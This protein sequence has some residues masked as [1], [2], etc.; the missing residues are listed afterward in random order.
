MHRLRRNVLTLRH[1]RPFDSIVADQNRNFRRNVKRA[2]E[3]ATEL[4]LEFAV[5]EGRLAVTQQLDIIA[6]IARASWKHT[7]RDG[8]QISVPYEGRQRRFFETLLADEDLGMTPFVATASVRSEPV[9]ALLC[10]QHARNFTGLLMFRDERWSAASPGLLLLGHIIDRAALGEIQRFDLNAIQDWLRHVADEI[11]TLANLVVFAPTV[12]GRTYAFVSQAMRR[13]RGGDAA[14][15]DAVP[16][17]LDQ[18]Q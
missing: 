14:S 2:R 6:R 17:T 12:V 4:G 13:L 3:A 8:K 1:V 16:V 9:A 11:H 7:G 5:H 15:N 10:L 18:P